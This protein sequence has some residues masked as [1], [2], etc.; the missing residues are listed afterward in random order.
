MTCSSAWAT[1]RSR[2]SA[3]A[4][5][6]AGGAGGGGA[7]PRAG[8]D[9]EKIAAGRLPTPGGGGVPK[10]RWSGRRRRLAAGRRVRGEDRGGRRPDRVEAGF[11]QVARERGQ[12][13][14]D[15]VRRGG[16]VHQD[17]RL[18]VAVGEV[19]QGG[20]GDEVGQPRRYVL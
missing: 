19:A 16:G 9:A 4:S 20:G 2:T 13:V 5:V 3:T 7:W 12:G 10:A 14:Q 18:A 17:H 11:P 15:R 6:A 8:A 1:A